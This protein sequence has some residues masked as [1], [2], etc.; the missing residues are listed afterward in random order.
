MLY[1]RDFK[2]GLSEDVNNPSLQPQFLFWVL[3]KRPF[4]GYNNP[5]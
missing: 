1:G 4:S 5:T 2:D 3:T